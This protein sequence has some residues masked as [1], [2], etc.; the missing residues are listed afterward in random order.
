MDYIKVKWN[1]SFPDE[2]VWLYSEIDNERWEVRKVEVFSD[3][4]MGFA[5]KNR[6]SDTTELGEEPLPELADIAADP[7]F[8]PLGITQSEFDAVWLSAT[9]GSP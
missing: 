4:R 7:Q 2:P 3:G 8:E 6:S 5:N 9:G 1:H